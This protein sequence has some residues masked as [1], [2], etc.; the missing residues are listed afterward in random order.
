MLNGKQAVFDVKIKEIQE[1]ELPDEDD[2]F[3]QD[4]S[5]FETFA[6]YR[7][8]ITDKLR[9]QKENQ[10]KNDKENQVMEKL[11]SQAEMDVP[12]A[13][14]EEKIDELVHNFSHQ[15]EYRGLQID[16]F[17]QYNNMTMAQLRENYH[18]NAL[19]Q[20]QVQLAL[21][22]VAKKENFDITPEDI[23]TEEER[24][25]NLYHIDM[26]KNT[27]DKEQVKKDLATQRAYDLVMD[28][29]VEVA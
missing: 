8:D 18:E 19:H 17:L 22:A 23:Q 14:I 7:A 25:I 11:V 9:K 20:I 16:D 27:I 3:A 1:K 21:E 2:D 12:P 26:T 15:L 6:E 28:S 5:D 29:A 4:V 13:M 24:I 10:A